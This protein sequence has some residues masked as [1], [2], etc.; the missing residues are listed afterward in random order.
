M[1]VSRCFVIRSFLSSRE[2][3]WVVIILTI[4][5]VILLFVEIAIEEVSG[6]EK[7]KHALEGIS[8]ASLSIVSFFMLEIFVTVL[9]FGPAYYYKE[10]GWGFRLFDA[11]IVATSFSL[12]L[13][14]RGSE[15]EISSLLIILR[16]WRIVKLIT[17]TT[18][19]VDEHMAERV[20]ELKLE[21][22]RLREENNKLKALLEP[23]I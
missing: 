2:F 20:E 7:H 9:A 14:L 3:H 10:E 6:M 18:I 12:E 17:T 23:M 15:E 11:C 21:N 22:A 5:N 8:A 16:L 1:G 19:V 13:A 4:I